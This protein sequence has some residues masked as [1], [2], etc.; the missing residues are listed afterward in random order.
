MAEKQKHLQRLSTRWLRQTWTARRS[1]FVR[2][3]GD[4]TVA[5]WR[6]DT[7][8]FPCASV[9][10]HCPVATVRNLVTNER[11][12]T[13]R[14]IIKPWPLAQSL[15]VLTGLFP[16][17]ITSQTSMASPAPSLPYAE[18][19]WLFVSG[20]L[21]MKKVSTD[22]INK[23]YLWRCEW[24]FF[25]VFMWVR[26]TSLP[27]ITESPRLQLSSDA[28]RIHQYELESVSPRKPVTDCCPEPE[29]YV[30]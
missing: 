27:H 30:T 13:I 2:W 26:R 3:S 19:S 15:T 9:L 5:H 17:Q 12:W 18:T 4:W 16:P 21:K 7:F 28:P 14:K 1:P 22:S 23:K 10:L 29:P 24:R 8:E 25:I 11:N 6:Q 20:A